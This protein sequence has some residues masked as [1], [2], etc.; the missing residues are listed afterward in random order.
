MNS[1]FILNILIYSLLKFIVIVNLHEQEFERIEISIDF[2]EEQP[3]GTIL[4][5]LNEYF[6]TKTFYEIDWKNVEIE[7]V[8]GCEDYYLNK[9][10]FGH[11][12]SNHFDREQLC[13]KDMF[14]SFHCEIYLN[15][16]KRKMKL[17]DLKMNLNDIDDHRGEFL[18]KISHYRIHCELFSLN[19]HF[20]LEQIHDDDF[21]DDKN[22]FYAL[23]PNVDIF[24]LNFDE[25]N[26]L[27]E[28]ILNEN[29]HSLKRNFYSFQLLAFNRKRNNQI[30][31]S[32]TIEIEIEKSSKHLQFF[33]DS[34]RKINLLGHI[35][36]EHYQNRTIFH[37]FQPEILNEFL[38]FNLSTGDLI[39]KNSTIFPFD[40]QDFH[41]HLHFIDSN[42]FSQEIFIEIFFNSTEVVL[43]EK[44]I[45]DVEIFLSKPLTKNLQEKQISIEENHQVPLKIGEIYCSQSFLSMKMNSNREFF[46]F[47]RLDDH[48]FEL[49][50]QKSFDFE[51]I[52]KVFVEISFE[53]A[54]HFFIQRNFEI[55]IE[56]LNDC[57]PNF[58]GNNF[59]LEIQENRFDENSI[60]E[61]QAND[62]DQLESLYFYLLH[63]SNEFFIDSTS[64]KIFLRHALDREVQS[65]YSLEIC[66]HDQIHHVCQLI[67]IEI[68]DVNDN[69]CSFSLSKI[70]LIIEENLPDRS[71]LYQFH[72]IDRDIQEN[73]NLHYFLQKSSQFL[74][75][76]STSGIL[77]IARSPFDRHLIENFTSS[78]VACDHFQSKFNS[79]CCS[80]DLDIKILNFQTPRILQLH[81]SQHFYFLI[82]NSLDPKAMPFLSFPKP[83]HSQ[84]ISSSIISLHPSTKQLIC[85]ETIS[86]PFN[87]TMNF[88]FSNL[89]FIVLNISFYPTRINY[90]R[91][92]ISFTLL[93]LLIL[94]LLV[95]FLCYRLKLKHHRHL[96]HLQTYYSFDQSLTPPTTINL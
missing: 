87:M 6:M 90:F 5:D 18:E 39:V 36:T 92:S 11:I 57:L 45:I 32:C 93:F 62:D 63:D 4:I 70:H 86:T 96:K 55:F 77:R 85:H 27:L 3:N 69:R 40:H 8:N 7:F 66:V 19:F 42:N 51:S 25:Q 16:M 49:I 95:V 71:F 21:N 84:Q 22:Y 91:P 31:D 72:A 53:F 30:E 52:Q 74:H 81:L 44:S 35:D 79:L 28:L 89:S 12:Y 17:I 54:E 13:G 20:Q 43:N 37:R 80:I 83:I 26:H 10:K 78:I 68:I 88:T 41:F 61:I 67:H 56:N 47:Q 76:N 46:D 9:T 94:L 82:L 65:N 14:C 33:L 60:F 2:D 15:E 23:Q 29:C 34:T 1:T 50:L 24:Q 38:I 73:A 64:G 48:F 59:S 58:I 75:L